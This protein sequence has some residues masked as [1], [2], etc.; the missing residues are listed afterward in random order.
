[1]VK[2]ITT[3][4]LAMDVI[5]AFIVDEELLLVSKDVVSVDDKTRHEFF[6]CLVVVLSHALRPRTL[7]RT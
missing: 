1:M 7:E 2:F 3:C 5:I 4:M 6:F